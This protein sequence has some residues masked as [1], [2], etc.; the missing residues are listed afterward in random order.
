MTVSLG[1]SSLP[2]GDYVINMTFRD[3]LGDA[4]ASRRIPFTVMPPA[5]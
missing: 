4:S 2:P 1:T 5:E 3:P